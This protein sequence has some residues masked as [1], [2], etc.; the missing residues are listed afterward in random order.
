MHQNKPAFDTFSLP[1]QT[2]FANILL[3]TTIYKI[4]VFRPN[5]TAKFKLP[6]F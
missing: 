2:A 1:K 4:Y 6:N 5:L 3:L